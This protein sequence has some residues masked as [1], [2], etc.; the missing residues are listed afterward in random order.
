MWKSCRLATEPECTSVGHMKTEGKSV[1]VM[2]GQVDASMMKQLQELLG[3]RFTELVDRFIDDG[4]RRIGLLRGALDEPDFEVIH[5]QAH[6]LKGSSRNMGANGLGN[7]CAEMEECGR[8]GMGEKLPAQFA[9]LEV[10]F[11][12]VCQ[13]LRRYLA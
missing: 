4:S 9:A 8:K 11:A 1:A 13:S 6:G 5:A 10:E 12:A 3:G 2:S 7:I